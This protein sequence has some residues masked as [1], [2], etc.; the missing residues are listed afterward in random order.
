MELE[1][2][3]FTKFFPKLQNNY[4]TVLIRLEKTYVRYAGLD[5]TIPRKL[6]TATRQYNDRHEKFWF[7]LPRTKMRI[8]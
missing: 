7:S 2:R 8:K 1:C 5:R 3:H 6:S 4:E